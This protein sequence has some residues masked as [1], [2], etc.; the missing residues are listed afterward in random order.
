MRFAPALLV[1]C[2]LPFSCFAQDDIKAECSKWMSI[3]IPQADVG[4]ASKDCESDDL[5]Y[6]DDGKGLNADYAAARQCAYRERAEGSNDP[7]AGIGIL[8]DVYAN[9]LDVARNIPLAKR[10]ACEYIPSTDRFNHLNALEKGEN[11]E[12]FD[13]CA[14]FTDTPGA[15]SC[16]SRDEK[17]RELARERR[18]QSLQTTWTLTQR[19]AFAKLLNAA[20]NFFNDVAKYEQDLGGAGKYGFELNSRKALNDDFLAHIEKLEQEKTVPTNPADFTLADKQLNSMQ[21]IA[22]SFQN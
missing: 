8:M 6:G 17:F 5:Y 11:K 14:D 19:Q 2:A 10:F 15:Y 18:W 21:P 7:I 16:E 20:T 22:R 3:Q 12:R 1:L 4:N 9:G 13:V